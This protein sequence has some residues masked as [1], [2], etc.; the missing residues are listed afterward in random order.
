MA[1]PDPNKNNP[2]T[3]KPWQTGDTFI[4]N[5]VT[6]VWSGT[7]GNGTWSKKTTIGVPG[8]DVPGQDITGEGSTDTTGVYDSQPDVKF[9][10]KS[11]RP[12][13]EVGSESKSWYQALGVLSAIRGKANQK[14]YK[15]YVD[16]LKQTP[17]WSGNVEASWK[18]LLYSA[19]AQNVTVDELLFKR[20]YT[21]IE[22]AGDGVS[23]ANSLKSYSRAIERSAIDQGIVL[24]K[25]LVKDLAAQA[26]AQSWDS[27]TLAEEV[28]RRGSISFE[29]GGRGLVA[30]NYSQLQN[31]ARD[32]GV[33]YNDAW[34][35]QA[36]KSIVKGT[37]N[38]E[39]WEA[40]IKEY[41]KQIYPA[42]AKQID[43]GATPASIASPY[44]R[45]MANILELDS[46]AIDLSDPVLSQALKNVDEEGNPI[47]KPLWQFE[48]ELRQDPRWK[49]TANA[50]QSMMAASRKVLQDFGL[51][52]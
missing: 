29:Q 25:N 14:E 48:R 49:F 21:G 46:E 33:S 11:N 26:I 47:V 28:A 34:F 18:D 43:A 24:D 52:S 16:A 9:E 37:S 6:Y 5:G 31:L 51:V 10:V 40:Q 39:D 8:A 30:K 4:E 7:T 32:Y 50:E 20:K 41:S 35:Q 12:G 42:F 15:R 3:G 22:G 19:A 38:L 45:T 13:G 1:L 17:F 44:V 27:A 2:D 23:K 36:T